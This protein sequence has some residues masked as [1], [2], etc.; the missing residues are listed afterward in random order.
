[1]T[2]PPMT[3]PVD[4]DWATAKVDNNKNVSSLEVDKGDFA[5]CYVGSRSFYDSRCT[6]AA[7]GAA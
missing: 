1:M 6:P 3:E 4:V 2:A 7:H 5:G